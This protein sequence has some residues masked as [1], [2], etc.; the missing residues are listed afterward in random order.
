M[1]EADV[2]SLLDRPKRRAI[3]D[4]AARLFM[5]DGYGAVSME[6]VAR[7]S[8][9][10]KATL[11][12]HFSGKERLFATIVAERCTALQAELEADP[13]WQAQDPRTALTSMGR[14]WL[15]FLLSPATV[16]IYRVVVAEAMRFPELAVAFYDAGPRAI[17]DWLTGWIAL[18]NRAGRLAAPDPAVAA[19]QF[20]ALLRTGIFF[21]ATL[22]IG[23]PPGP[24]ESRAV[25]D[26]AVGTFLRA[27]GSA[28]ARRPEG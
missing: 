3:V 6:A 17:R 14:R 15:G 18:Q 9:V 11:Y 5:R 28:G 27:F 21:R 4:A 7:E 20:I 12:A 26:E 13:D 16:A 22:G 25:I 23:A 19:E 24:V 8:G 1:S 10:S 2:P